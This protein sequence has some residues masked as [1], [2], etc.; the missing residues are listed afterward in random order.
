MV[1]QELS[2]HSED[3]DILYKDI[4]DVAAIQSLDIGLYFPVKLLADYYKDHGD[5]NE[6]AIYYRKALRLNPKDY[7]CWLALGLIQMENGSYAAAEKIF[8][9]ICQIF[10]GQKNFALLKIAI[11]KTVSGI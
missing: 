3:N 4:L 1:L 6:A 5:I 2:K 9:K 7:D 8:E 10:P 11:I